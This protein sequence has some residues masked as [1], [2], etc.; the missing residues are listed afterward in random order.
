MDAGVISTRYARAIYEYAFE[1]GEETVVHEQML[2]LAKNFS[3]LPGL[4]QV[5][6]DPTVM[7]DRKI[8]LLTTACNVPVC[9]TLQ[10][11]IPLIVQRRRSHCMENI[12]RMYDEI[13]RKA[14][15]IVTV[16]LTLVEP[17]DDRMKA[18]LLPV[19]AQITDGKVDFQIQTDAG[20]IGG[21][22]LEVEDKR[23]D[24][25]VKEQ[26]RKMSYEL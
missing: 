26:L 2:S 15:G 6:S 10:R 19:I 13:Y 5:I 3:L 18:E 4:R 23:L 14:K 12:A 8:G 22:V 21:F 24:A 16:R 17:A 7:A 20:L 1:Q 9:K 25:S 11:A